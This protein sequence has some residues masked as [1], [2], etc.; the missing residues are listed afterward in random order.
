[1][2]KRSILSIIL[3]TILILSS[4]VMSASALLTG[5]M[6]T[7]GTVSA[8]DARVVLRASVGLEKLND[9]GKK[10]ADADGDG[11]VSASDARLV[12]RAS[13]GLESLG[14]QSAAHPANHSFTTVSMTGETKCSI[15][16]CDAT[17]PSFNSMVN[18]L[19]TTESGVVRFTRIDEQISEEFPELKSEWEFFAWMANPTTKKTTS[20]TGIEENRYLT[21][22]NFCSYYQSFVSDLTDSEVASKKIETVSTV[23][24]ASSLPDSI[25]VKNSTFTTKQMKA[26]TY[27][28]LYKITV[29]VK[30]STYDL[31]DEK[32]YTSV[33]D[34]IYYKNFFGTFIAPVKNELKSEFGDYMKYIDGEVTPSVTVTYYI[35]A[36]TLFPVAAKYSCDMKI[37][38]SFFEIN[39]PNSFTDNSYVFFNPDFTLAG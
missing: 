23:D 36:D 2:K 35:D 37:K 14:E 32:S 10:L 16:G 38:M 22:N 17:L 4:L 25:T 33:L 13:V 3:A 9:T 30:D 20:F 12:L 34:K 24:F 11:T 1:M 28:D 39:L 26:Q 6:D 27:G 19:K 18:V 29:T 21:K 8:S 31:K 5:D 15:A 7:D